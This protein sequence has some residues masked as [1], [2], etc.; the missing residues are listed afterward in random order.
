MTTG[1]TKK[2]PKINSIAL[3]K[4]KASLEEIIKLL[5]REIPE[6][7][8]RY[9]IQSI[10]IFG[11]FVREERKKPQDLDV[12]VEFTRAPTL[13]EFIRLEKNLSEKIGLPVD[14]VMK[15]ALKPNIARRILKE[16]IPL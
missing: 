11:S 8:S 3:N 5:R 1:K 10:G 16:V 2:T 4:S 15:S 13:F 7:T 12:L 9:K 6:L 14:L